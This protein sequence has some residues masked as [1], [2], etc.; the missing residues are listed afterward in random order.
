MKHLLLLYILL[1]TIVYA[2]SPADLD[3]ITQRNTTIILQDNERQAFK[4]QSKKT[5]SNVIDTDTYAL[6]NETII[7]SNCFMINKFIFHN[8]QILS[9]DDLRPVI[10]FYQNRCLSQT[11]ISNLLRRINNIYI[12]KGYITSQSYLQAQDLSS[13]VLHIYLFEGKL[14]NIFFNGEKSLET[15]T[16][17]PNLKDKILNLRDIE[18]GL[19]QL[20]RLPRNQATLSLQAGN[21]EGYSDINII[22]KTAHFISGS[23]AI[24][25][26]GIESTGRGQ[27]S[28]Q[29]YADNL[30]HLNSQ[31]SLS[32]NGS[33]E[34]LDEKRSTGYSLNWS[35]PYGYF[36]FSTGYR[37]FLYRSTIYGENSNYIS[38]GISESYYSNLDYTCYRNK[39]LILKTNIGLNFKQNLNFIANELIRTSSTKLTVGNLGFNAAYTF[40]NTQL[41]ANFTL[42][43]GLKLFD[44]VL[45]DY[46][47]YKKAQFTKYTLDVSLNTSFTMYEIP[48]SL[49]STISG[50]YSNDKL[51]SPELI[52]IGGLY[53]VRGFEHMGYFGEI[54]AYSHNDLTYT[55]SMQL[56]GEGM[57]LSPYIGFDM[58]VIE[59]DKDIYKY[60]VGSGVG[61]KLNHNSLSLSFDFGVPLYAY[62]PIAEENYT[63]SFSLSYQF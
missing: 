49:S 7:A 22:N 10:N 63:S 30:L 59:Y 39:N 6:D 47:A 4:K 12:S 40:D 5:N 33:L 20:N 9:Q 56:F 55:H 62:E 29:L 61:L 3:K 38:S 19:D 43:Q 2:I 13:G 45:N 46:H 17:F 15:L 11:H 25:S 53:T 34:Q 54:G 26:T 1:H 24:N 14:E 23:A 36:L 8:T 35:I 48:F 58:G 18:M 27:G 52:S 41:N 28:I 32:I 44:P 42:H 21:T 16:A 37:E 50:Q 31:L 51:Y 57:Q 60:M